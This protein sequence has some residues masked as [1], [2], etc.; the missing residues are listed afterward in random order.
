VLSGLG[1][2]HLAHAI[3]I[4]VKNNFPE[5]TVLYVSCEQFTNQFIDAVKNN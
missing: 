1:K 5:K 2:T 4:E 3:G